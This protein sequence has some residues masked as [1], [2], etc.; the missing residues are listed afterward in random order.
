[1]H[2]RHLLPLLLLPACGDPIDAPFRGD[3]HGIDPA[4]LDSQA[5]PVTCDPHLDY[6]P[7][8]GPHDGG[9]H[10][11]NIQESCPPHPGHDNSDFIGGSH[12]GNDLFG[13]E[14]T[15]VRA[16]VSG[17]AVRVGW[18]TVGG[19]RVT[20]EDSCGWQY[21]AA[22]LESITP[23]LTAG[24]S[25]EAGEIIGTLGDT[26]NAAGTHPHVHFSIYPD[27]DY[28]AGID[29]FPYLQQVDA[30]SCTGES[31]LG[32]G[33]TPDPPVNPCT[34]ANIVSQ[35]N[36]GSFAVVEGEV[37][38]EPEIGGPT[39]EFFTA[40][41]F[42]STVAL[43]VGRWGPWISHP[44]KWEVDV[45][46]PQTPTA[47]TSQATYDVA[48]LGGHAMKSV[49]QGAH[50]GE[51]VSLFPG[52]PF[53]FLAGPRGYVGLTNLGA[54]GRIAMDA[55]R[56][57][58][59]GEL[60]GAG[61]G[62]ACSW[63]TDCLGDLLCG[64]SGT[65]IEDCADIGCDVDSYCDAATGVCVVPASDG[66]GLPEPE[67]LTADT[68]G[69]G[70]PNYLEGESDVDGDGIPAWWDF[71]SDGDGIGD[72]VEGPFD[73]DGDGLIDSNDLDADNDGISDSIEVGRY[74][75]EPID[76]D[77]DGR[78][79]FQDDDSDGDSIPDAMEAGGDPPLDTDGDATPDYLDT[80]SDNDGTDDGTEAT[81]GREDWD[82]AD[83]IDSDG[84]GTPD[85]LQGRGTFEDIPQPEPIESGCACSAEGGAAARGGVLALLGLI[86]ALRRRRLCRA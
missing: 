51:W 40:E 2:L 53:K 21:Y 17:V 37:E 38:A 75:D 1:M 27:G 44:G 62:D 35:D 30:G 5:L 33:A 46:I 3:W 6:Y 14:G 82:P 34:D 57:R 4:D 18:N 56:F 45:R 54:D 66:V 8:A 25:V 16:V 20:I 47:L 23:G 39:P 52:Q 71:D 42:S 84:D 26:G 69:D 74:E 83:P 55:V 10:T 41:P 63:S 49:N 22:H 36:D 24:E 59:I 12:Y 65:C 76:S 79:D 48:F 70:I 67:N 81:G 61:A 43:A 78:P 19:L 50:K 15:P 29:P 31:A 77:L 28:D 80:D 72:D 13:Q 85:Y 32:P 58:Y 64:P 73:T 11:N 60:G 86:P 9:W 7:V 68:D